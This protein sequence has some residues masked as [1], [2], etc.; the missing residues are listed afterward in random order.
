MAEEWAFP[1]TSFYGSDMDCPATN[2]SD[3][4]CGMDCP[5][6]MAGITGYVTLPENDAASVMAAL[7]TVGPLA[8][9]VAASEWKNYESGVFDGCAYDPMDINHVVQ[10]VGYGTDQET[11]ADF[12]LV[13]NSW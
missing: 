10:L 3:C 6:G 12:W 9:N 4:S 5:C 8:V 2:I 13:R 7:A 1:Y 11:G